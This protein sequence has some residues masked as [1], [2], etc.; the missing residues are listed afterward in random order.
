MNTFAECGESAAVGV[1][2]GFYKTWS[3]A[4][5][6]FGEGTPRGGESFD[7]SSTLRQL[8]SNVEGAKP[9][10]QWSGAAAESYS[11]ANEKQGRVL[12]EMAG[13]DQRLR[14]EVDRAANVVSAGRRDLDTVRQWVQGAA[15]LVP[16]P[17]SSRG[18]AMLMPIVSKGSGEIAEI[19]QRSNAESN[20]IAGR[21]RG[22]DS[23]YRMLGGDRKLGAGD[24][25]DPKEGDTL[26]DE[27]KKQQD[28][29]KRAQ[30]DVK[31]AL[32]GDKGA[33]QRVQNVLN[34]ITPDQ[35][36]GQPKL[37]AEQQAYLSQLQAQQ[38]LRSVDQLEE[39][40]N[41]GAKGIMA[42]SWQLMSNPK[43]EFP[44]TESVDG[45]LQGEE[46]ATGGFNQLPPS[47]QSVIQSPGVEQHQNLQKIADIVNGGNST[48]YFQHD[49]DL[50]RGLMHK[51]ADMMEAPEWR[52]GDPAFDN[53][54]DLDMPWEPDPIPPHAD[55]ER[56][57]SSVLEVVSG[58]HQVVHD[59]ITGQVEPGNEFRDE[60]KVNSEHL[61]YNLTHEEWDDNGAAAGSLFDWTKSAA[62]GP[63]ADIAAGTAHTYADYIGSHSNDLLHLNGNNVIGLEGTHTLGDVNPH[64]TRAVAEGLTP[65]INN[66]AG[67]SGG[68]PG[69]EPLDG[70][71]SFDAFAMG[72]TKGLFAVLNSEQTTAE[73]WNAEVYKQALLHETA[74][75][76]D[77][78][79]FGA[80]AHL[81]SSAM[82]R[83]LVDAGSVG[84]F[85]AFAQNQN[86]IDASLQEWKEFG[87]DAALTTLSSTGASLPGAGPMTGEMIDKVGGALR[88]EIIGTTTPIDPADPINDMS[89]Q[90]AAN[91]LLTTVSLMGGDVPLPQAHYENGELVGYPPG[92]HA[93]VVGGEIVRPPDVSYA[94]HQAA[95]VRAAGDMLGPA[96]GGYSAI[97]GMITVF[98]GVTKLPNPHG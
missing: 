86:Q 96:A 77:P 29:E 70:Q 58:D 23:E 21:I 27:E 4:R 3:N 54:L 19:L 85:D 93:V 44:K 47:V 56:T 14:R 39:A 83:G 34:T 60:F 64:L 37:N 6:A 57:A 10:S 66:I 32:D 43:I 72:D 35:Q 73:L 69:F 20:A 15:A 31:A 63:E 90:T 42:D 75:A 65:Y 25:K 95:V 78:S 13:L 48:S 49:T 5:S 98:N 2:D 94:D 12:G 80:D 76:K 87:Y 81:T 79:N 89:P 38:K 59:A 84:A 11:T 71:A 52:N 41:K 88:D 46:M 62:T 24:G 40:A 7:A 92:A 55:L 67:L 8:Q 74:F 51:V 1:L 28:L 82:L 22:L 9:G 53:P 97:E 33:V 18:Q 68:L 26:T 50:D 91:R 61:L 36:S 45:A 17:N 30:A 16:D